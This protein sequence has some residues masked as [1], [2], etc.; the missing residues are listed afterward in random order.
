M[1]EFLTTK[2]ILKLEE[3]LG[4]GFEEALADE[5]Q[6]GKFIKLIAAT[7]IDEKGEM[8]YG[9]AL[10]EATALLERTFKSEETKN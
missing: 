10:K 9:Q 5:K 6:Q 7:F 4:F 2:D 3:K 8:P 1:K